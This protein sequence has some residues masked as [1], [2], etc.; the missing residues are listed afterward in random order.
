MCTVNMFECHQELSLI[1]Y[2][3]FIGI[4]LLLYSQFSRHDGELGSKYSTNKSWVTLL[5]SQE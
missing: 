2:H 4:P 3:D 5:A 1:G